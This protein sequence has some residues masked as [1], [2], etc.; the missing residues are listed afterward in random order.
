MNFVKMIFESAIVDKNNLY[1]FCK[2]LNLLCQQNLESGKCIIL[3]SIPEEE[4]FSERLCGDIQR[5]EDILILIPLRAKYVWLYNLSTAKW[6]KIVIPVK[7]CDYQYFDSHIYDN[8]L[9]MIGYW[10]NN[11]I[12]INLE[13]F[14]INVFVEFDSEYHLGYS[15]VIVNGKLYVVSQ[16]CQEIKAIELMTGSIET[17]QIDIGENGLYGIAWDGDNF[18]IISMNGS[19]FKMTSDGN[20][21]IINRESEKIYPRGIVAVRNYILSASPNNDKSFLIYNQ[22]KEKISGAGI[23]FIKS[24]G[25]KIYYETYDGQFVCYDSITGQSDVCNI[26]IERSDFKEYLNICARKLNGKVIQESSILDLDT[27]IS[28]VEV[29]INKMPV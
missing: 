9:Y 3:G 5:Y 28:M 1:F 22:I 2:D 13:D 19:L 7:K 4:I 17:V 26:E 23:I 25:T 8:T 24:V 15:S 27:W 16:N 21:E 29:D 20:I 10:Q 12:S 11:I 6:S 14:T 18:W